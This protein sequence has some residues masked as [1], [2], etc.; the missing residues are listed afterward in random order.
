MPLINSHM[1][2]KLDCATFF[3]LGYLSF[4]KGTYCFHEF[5]LSDFQVSLLL[6]PEKNN[7]KMCCVAILFFFSRLHFTWLYKM[8]L[9]AKRNIQNGGIWFRVPYFVK[10][11]DIFYR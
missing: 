6:E 10:L 11:S 2:K 8:A 9:K 1:Y 5:F 7:N 4:L 3:F